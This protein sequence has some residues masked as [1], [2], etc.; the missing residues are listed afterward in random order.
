M[1]KTLINRWVGICVLLFFVMPGFAQE[2]PAE[3]PSEHP[4][5]VTS[6]P[7]TK[8]NLAEAVVQYVKSE[9]NRNMKF[10]VEDP[11]TGK[12]LELVL[13]KVHKDRLSA[14][15]DDLY[16]ACADFKANDDK[17]YDLDVF[18]NGKS[19]EELSFSEFLVHKEEG[20]ERYGWQE[21]KGVWKRVQ[22]EPEEPAVTLDPEEAED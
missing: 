12:N 16:F 1:I 11:E 3:H 7:I 6:T 10:I 13:L 5:K 4:S 17:V 21:E 20:K 18:M 19:A 8:D 9:S 22:F 15:G 2:H 14:V